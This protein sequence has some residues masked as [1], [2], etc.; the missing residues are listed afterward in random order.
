[1]L[2][3]MDVVWMM[4]ALC[5]C[6]GLLYLSYRIEPHFVSKDGQRFMATM[7]TLGQHDVPTSRIREVRGRFLDEG[8]IRLDQKQGMR[9]TSEAWHVVGRS[10]IQAK[11]KVIFTVVQ[12]GDAP[13]AAGNDAAQG[14][15]RRA[16]LRLPASSTLVAR[17]DELAAAAAPSPN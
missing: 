13:S 5:V 4:L 10:P 11:G 17:L 15:T 7:Q 2:G 14:A 9:R 12:G 3:A 6:A 1:M 16:A 8:T